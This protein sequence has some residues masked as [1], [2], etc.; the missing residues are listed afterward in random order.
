MRSEATT[1]I[2]GVEFSINYNG[3]VKTLRSLNKDENG[4]YI[5]LQYTNDEEKR[6]QV[7]ECLYDFF[8]REIG[9]TT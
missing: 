9:E 1:I 4:F 8:A 5:T 6:K 2:D 3:K 7:E